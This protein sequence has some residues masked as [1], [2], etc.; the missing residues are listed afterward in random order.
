MM[1]ID[2]WWLFMI[3]WWLMIIIGD[4]NGDGW[5]MDDHE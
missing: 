3:D 2:R 1:M 4:D 5:L